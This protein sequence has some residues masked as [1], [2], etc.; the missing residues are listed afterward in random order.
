MK[1]LNYFSGQKVILTTYAQGLHEGQELTIISHSNDDEYECSY[2]KDNETFYEN[3][4]EDEFR[5]KTKYDELNE[6]EKSSD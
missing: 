6:N 5:L 2:I 4:F 1:R 3:F